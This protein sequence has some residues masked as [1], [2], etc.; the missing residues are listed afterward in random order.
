L[1]HISHPVFRIFILKIS[2]HLLPFIFFSKFFP[3]KSPCTFFFPNC[4]M[5]HSSLLSDLPN[6]SGGIQTRFLIV[7]FPPY[8][9]V[10]QKYHFLK[11]AILTSKLSTSGAN[12]HTFPLPE[13][14][15][16]LGISYVTSYLNATTVLGTIPRTV[17]Y[18]MYYVIVNY[19]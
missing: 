19:K 1:I 17:T 9:L 3:E 6:T 15:K 11:D 13:R 4:Y 18:Q 12:R 2:F 8:L 16:L 7:H 10:S 14:Q 5:P